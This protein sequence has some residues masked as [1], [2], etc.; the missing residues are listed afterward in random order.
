M[1]FVRGTGPTRHHRLA[2]LATVATLGASMLILSEAV[3]KLN[4]D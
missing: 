3:T 4:C 2:Q 1:E